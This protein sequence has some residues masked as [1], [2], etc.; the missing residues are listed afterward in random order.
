MKRRVVPE[1]GNEEARREVRVEPRPGFRDVLEPVSPDE[2]R[3]HAAPP[4]REDLR[5]G[6]HRLEVAV[7][8]PLPDAKPVA[9]PYLEEYLPELWLKDDRDA[10]EKSDTAPLRSCIAWV[11]TRIPYAI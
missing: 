8:R 10:D 3:E 5:G 6:E 11:F 7:L 4:V 9:L 2:D 1:D